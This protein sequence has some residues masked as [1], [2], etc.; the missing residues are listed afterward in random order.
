[1]PQP[2]RG[3]AS[4]RGP[5]RSSLLDLARD[6][7]LGRQDSISRRLSCLSLPGDLHPDPG[8]PGSQVATVLGRIGLPWWCRGQSVCLQYGRTGFDLWIGK[9]PW[10]RKWQ[11]TPVFLPGE[12]HGWRSLVGYSPRVA[13]IRTRLS[14]FTSLHFTSLHL[15]PCLCIPILYDKRLPA[16]A[17]QS[18]MIKGTSLCCCC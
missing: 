6:P 5:R 1:M 9:I 14:D 4:P 7:I 17:F 13:K 15:T 12:S 11:P 3:S 16:C 2:A 18:S 10:R 8:M